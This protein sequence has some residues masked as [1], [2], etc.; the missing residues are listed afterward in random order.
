MNYKPLHTINETEFGSISVC[1]DVY[2]LLLAFKDLKFYLSPMDISCFRFHMFR[3]EDTFQWFTTLLDVK[4]FI[5]IDK[6]NIQFVLNHSE[7]EA[8]RQ[9][10]IETELIIESRLLTLPKESQLRK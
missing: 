4:A 3:Q 5:K 7:I 1:C 10:L 8:L 9:L 2:T 6:L